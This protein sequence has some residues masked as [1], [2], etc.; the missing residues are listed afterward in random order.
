MILSVLKSLAGDI[1]MRGVGT[2]VRLLLEGLLN[3]GVNQISQ[4]F[5]RRPQRLGLG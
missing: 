4:R 2:A 3:P 5:I 1:G